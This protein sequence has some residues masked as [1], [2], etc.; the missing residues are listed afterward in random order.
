MADAE[1]DAIHGP[2][3]VEATQVETDLSDETQDFRLLNHLNFL[4]DTSSSSLPRRGEKDFE[5]NPTEFQAD[6]LSASR[7]AMHNALSHPR[8]HNPKN[9]VVGIYAPDGYVPP[10]PKSS[11]PAYASRGPSIS[12]DACVY[13]PTPKGQHFKSIGQADKLNRVWLLPEEGLYLL[14]RGSLDIRW[15]DSLTGCEEKNDS[16]EENSALPAIPMSLQAAYSCFVGRG[17]LTLERYSVY[18]GLK[19]LGYALTR[20]PGWDDA[21]VPENTS[22]N[23]LDAYTNPQTRGAGLSGIFGSLFNWIHDPLSTASTAAGP[24][25]GCGIHRNYSDVYRKLAITPW[26]DPVLAQ[27]RDA[28]DTAAPFRVVFHAYKPATPIKKSAFPPPDFRIA[29]VS[30]R[31]QTTIPTLSQLGALLESTPL[32]PP[33]GEKMERMLYMRLRHGYRNVVMAVVDQ[34]VVSYIRIADSAFGNEKLY[35]VKNVPRPKRHGN[36]KGS[37]KL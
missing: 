13:V 18:T 26:Y 28:L 2:S 23:Q 32:N 19:R 37:R 27:Q 1:E 11:N 16:G 36:Y 12:P 3:T 9:Q 4:T 29:V 21:G 5:P 34:G 22:D 15:P 30:S 7:Q 33:H 25:V 24:V 14:E 8:I 31:E 35:D 17:G 20:A 10:Q 6:I